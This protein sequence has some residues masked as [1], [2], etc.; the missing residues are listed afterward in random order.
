MKR[1]RSVAALVAV[2]LAWS[3]LCIWC[4][5]KPADA[6]SDAERRVL[7]QAPKL[8]VE[9]LLNGTFATQFEDYAVDQ[10]PMRDE[11]RAMKTLAAL[12]LFMQKDTNGLYV[13]DGFV[14]K[15]LY[16]CDED[17][18]AYAAQ[19]FTWLYDRYLGDAA[20][21]YVAVVP[22]KGCYLAPE[23]G[24]PYVE[25]ADIQT[26][27]VSQ[28]PEVQ[29]IDLTDTLQAESYFAG[30]PHW[31][32]EQ[33]LPAARA[34]AEA[35]HVSEPQDFA[36]RTLRT[37]FKGGYIGQIAL[38]LAGETMYA[39]TNQIIDAMRVTIL[40][41]GTW[42]GVLDEDKL[43]SRDPYSAYL[44]GAA[45]IVTIDNPNADT[46]RRLVI[47]RDSFASALAPILAQS[48]AQVTLVDIRY[49]Q[50][51]L[52]GQYVDFTDCDVLFLYSTLILNESRSLR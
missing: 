6:S 36:L 2:A 34:L 21:V 40:P 31:R 26:L 41:E 14:A 30:D 33:L 49:I 22:D 5:C 39:A 11:F 50:S 18:V 10:F 13:A 19:R 52:V 42:M 25:A 7:A 17:A 46:A 32:Q 4:W 3:C 1:N 38:P 23:N 37:D 15:I 24:Y 45:A 43:Y 9:T 47:F 27:L 8:R 51:E 12:N 28:T 35:M 20:G 48:Y 16:P 44:S 29:S